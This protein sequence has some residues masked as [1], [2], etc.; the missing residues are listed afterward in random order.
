LSVNYAVAHATASIGV[1]R[2]DGAV[3]LL[4]RMLDAP[5][6]NPDRSLLLHALGRAH[7]KQGQYRQAFDSYVQSNALRCLNFDPLAHA[8]EVTRTI[9]AFGAES[10]DSIELIGSPSDA[11]IFIVG[12][13]RSGTSLIEQILSSHSQVHGAGELEFVRLMASMIGSLAGGSLMDGLR[14]VSP[15]EFER[16]ATEHL[17]GLLSQSERASFVTDKMPSNFLYLGLIQKLYPNAKIIHSKRNM[18]DTCVSCFRQNFNASYS[19][20]TR[21]DWLGA[22]YREYERMMAHWKSVITLPIYEM[23]YESLVTNPQEEIPRLV[24]FCGLDMEPECLVPHKNKRVVHT[25]S[26]A[27][28]RQPIYTGSVGYADR[29]REFLRP[30]VQAASK[31]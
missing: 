26:R 30:L 29:Y 19:Y 6:P 21:L 9:E 8:A 22:F 2:A 25:A 15:K 16:N 12:M 4:V 3:A 20:S 18:L 23:N 31:P 24:E 11:P 27:Q 1:G 7:D 14:K 17:V 10:L 28:V 5:R 13:P